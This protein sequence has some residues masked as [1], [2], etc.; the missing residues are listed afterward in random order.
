LIRP[1]WPSE[2]IDPTGVQIHYNPLADELTL[3]FPGRPRRGV[4][5]RIGSP[6]RESAAVI[7]DDETD[8]VVGIQ[9]MPL[10]LSAVRER[11]GWGVLVWGAL[12]DFRFEESL[13]REAIGDFLDDVHDLFERYWRPAP[14]M[15]EQLAR[16][17]GA[18]AGNG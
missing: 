18:E 17:P 13:L 3:Y 15:E 6:G 12:T 4:S 10:L 9:I 16:L 8:E 1:R 2:P 5:D 14:P 7:V 11:P